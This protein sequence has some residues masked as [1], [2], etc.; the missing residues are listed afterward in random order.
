MNLFSMTRRLTTVAAG[1]VLGAVLVAQP[2]AAADR[3][4]VLLEDVTATWCYYCQFAG[5]AMDMHMDEKPDTFIGL[6]IHGSSDPYA[7]PWGYPWRIITFYSV[8]GYPTYFADG[9]Y[10]QIGAGSDQSAYNTMNTFYNARMSTETD[11]LIDICVED[12]GNK[13]YNVKMTLEL[14]ADAQAMQVWAYI[15]EVCD[16]YPYSS[17]NKY[18]NC[19]MQAPSDLYTVVDLVPGAETVVEYQYTVTDASWANK[20]HLK[21]VGWAQQN[22]LKWQS[23][24]YNTAQTVYPFDECESPCPED[25]NDDGL[26]DI[27]DLFEVLNHWGETSGPGDVNN[28]G[29]I[30]IDDL[31]A[32]INAWGPC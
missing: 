10:R 32:V 30:N 1:L 17:D 18:R 14:E 12:L 6:Q 23:E 26:V 11:V 31:F 25:T 8:S 21:F 9:F 2:A 5:R 20:E 7:I 13:T 19:L 15:V 3:N 27:N 16:Y 4:A 28:D 24:I 29:V 22:K